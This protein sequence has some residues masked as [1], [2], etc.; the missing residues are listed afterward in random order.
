MGN[1]ISNKSKPSLVDAYNPSLNNWNVVE[2]GTDFNVWRN[3]ITEEEIQEYRFMVND[4]DEF[5][6][7]KQAFEARHNNN[8]L[9]ASKFFVDDTEK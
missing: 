2:R 1:L 7:E 5:N 8:N 4:V 3:S 9:I 6:K